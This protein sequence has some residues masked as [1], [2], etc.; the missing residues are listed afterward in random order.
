M[1]KQRKTRA[2]LAGAGIVVA[3][4]AAMAAPKNSAQKK[5]APPPPPPIAAVPAP[6][7]A[8]A[9]APV[10]APTPVEP[11]VAPAERP[12]VEVVFVLDTTGSMSGL[13]QG[14]KQKIWSIANHIASAQPTPEVRIGLVAYR[15]IGDA[16]VT[17]R[18]PLSADLDQVFEHLMAFRADGGGDTPEHVNKALYEAVNK[19]QWSDGAMKLVFL[20][21]DAP[22]HMD[23]DDGYDYHKIAHDAARKE[24]RIHTI[25][26]GDD[27]ETAVAWR[28][29]SKIGRGTYATIEQGGGVVATR[30]PMDAEMARLGRKLSDTTVIYGD[31]ESR[32]R[33]EGKASV[34]AGAPA[35][36]AADRGGFFAKT[37]A[38]LDED[39]I[40]DK[41]AAGRVDVGSLDAAKLPEPMR[42]MAPAER[43]TYVVEKKKEREETM[44]ELKALAAKRDAY[45]KEEA[46]KAPAKPGAFDAAVNGAITEQAKDYGMKY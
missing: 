12:K 43:K 14:A 36:A 28:D 1:E 23:Y 35:S 7:P 25:R 19:M 9:P 13:I 15:D 30:T 16:Y 5:P 46:K 26:C 8:P 18:Y 2:I 24:I 6:A 11:Q 27:P 17:K 42:A 32:R 37:G 33:F 3:V 22:P 4:A 34:A 31:G 21:G 10:A 38:A 20:V 39:D 45:I 44:N 40:V 41:A 29:I